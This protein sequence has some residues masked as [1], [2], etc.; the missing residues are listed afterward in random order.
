MHKCMYSLPFEWCLLKQEL[1][2]E[3]TKYV[4]KLYICDLF[5]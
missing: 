2:K 3:I 1:F 4:M 5:L